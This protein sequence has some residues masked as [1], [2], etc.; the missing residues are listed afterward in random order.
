MNSN[1][2]FDPALLEE[3]EALR[4]ELWEPYRTIEKREWLYRYCCLVTGIDVPNPIFGSSTTNA[5]LLEEI[6]LL[7]LA[8]ENC[9]TEEESTGFLMELLVKKYGHSWGATVALGTDYSLIEGHHNVWDAGTDSL[10]PHQIGRLV[11]S[12]RTDHSAQTD[13]RDVSYSYRNP[14]M[15]ETIDLYLY[16]SRRGLNIP[17]GLSESVAREAGATLEEAL[18]IAKN[19]RGEEIL[20]VGEWR[21]EVFRSPIDDSW[22]VATAA[23]IAR[24]ADG[25]EIFSSL[26]MTGFGGGFAKVRWTVALEN[27]GGEDWRARQAK[28]EADLANYFYTFR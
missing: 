5:E 2:R 18:D 26:A 14:D 1:D 16:A 28:V 6:N 3:L 12:R 15:P 13:R 19:I 17:N 24:T 25:V 7:K 4:T 20:E 21:C 22:P 9:F 27:V 8:R 23:W 10:L 11:I